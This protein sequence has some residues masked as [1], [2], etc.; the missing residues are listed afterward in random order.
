MSTD[1]TSPPRRRPERVAGTIAALAVVATVIAFAL[2]T[3]SD[4]GSGATALD[5][6][7]PDALRAGDFRC[8]EAAFQRESYARGQ[9]ARLKLFEAGTA[10][11]LQLFRVGATPRRS[12]G[13]A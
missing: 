12:R 10:V 9:V 1:S 8:I 3:R 7:G 4:G 6:Q 11:E 5:A 13:P 2:P